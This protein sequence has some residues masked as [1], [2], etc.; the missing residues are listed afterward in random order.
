[1]SLPTH[2]DEDINSCG[3]QHDPYGDHDVVEGNAV[4]VFQL[5]AEHNLR[6]ELEDSANE[7]PETMG[8]NNLSYYFV[9]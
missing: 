9:I 2:G 8:G 6:D 7:I 1:L 5:E 3:G 4:A